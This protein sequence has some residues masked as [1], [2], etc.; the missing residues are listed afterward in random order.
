MATNNPPRYCYDPDWLNITIP[1]RFPIITFFVTISLN[2]SADMPNKFTNMFWTLSMKVKKRLL[3]WR[4]C[5]NHC[6]L[7]LKIL[8]S[9]HN[10]K[11]VR[12]Q[13]SEKEVL[14]S[15]NS[16]SWLRRRKHNQI[17][18]ELL[19][20]PPYIQQNPLRQEVWRHQQNPLKA[21]EP[22]D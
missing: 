5:L 22:F 7:I 8:H 10:Q 12:Y 18:F 19:V 4:Q 15:I 6:I 3:T 17:F 2:G 9:W 1:R 21:Q 20:L 13:L 16:N 11:R 14:F